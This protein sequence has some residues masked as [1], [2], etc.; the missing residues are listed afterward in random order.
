[1]LN[2]APNVYVPVEP[3]DNGIVLPAV[4]SLIVHGSILAFIIFSHQ[5]P[6]LDDSQSI[7]TT[8]ITPEELASLQA[9]I[10]A[11]R[12]TLAVGGVPNTPEMNSTSVPAT[13]SDNSFIG[14]DSAFSRGISS[15]FNKVAEPTQDPVSASSSDPVFTEMTELDE[16]PS[17]E[18]TSDA[19]ESTASADES[20]PVNSAPKVKANTEGQGQV[21]ATFPSGTEGNKNKSSSGGG[22]A[23]Q[24][25]GNGNSKSSGGDI[26]GALV[27]LIEPQWTPP[28]GRVGSTVSVSVTVDENGNVLSVNANTSD[29]ELKQSLESAVNRASPLTP[30]IGTNKRRLKLTFVVR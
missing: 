3:V 7:E 2:R 1:M 10:K 24:S 26:S 9:D 16:M 6:K 18:Q 19:T 23:A 5:V 15:I 12:E 21:A 13:S 11:N 20:K 27:N 30:V 4:L 29:A 22:T 17:T 8:I 25:T 28:V 14:G